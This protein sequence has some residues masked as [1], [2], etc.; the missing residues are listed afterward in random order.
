MTKYKV[1]GVL[2]FLLGIPILLLSVSFS[3]FVIPKLSQLYL[4]FNTNNSGNII[5]SYIIVLFLLII[6]VA[7]IF[8]GIKGFSNTSKKEIYF[9]YGLIMAVVTFILSGLLVGLMTLSVILPIYNLTSS[10]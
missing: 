4:E 7:N 6:A 5:F 3:I 1:V 8:L 9:K 10:L 2:D